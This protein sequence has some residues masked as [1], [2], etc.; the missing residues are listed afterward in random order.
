MYTLAP[1]NYYTNQ[2]DTVIRDSDKAHIPF[3]ESNS[4]YQE[5]LKWVAAGN[6]PTPANT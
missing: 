5:Y 3:D 6:T 1:L 4:D 2:Q